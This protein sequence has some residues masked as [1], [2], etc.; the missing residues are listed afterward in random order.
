RGETTVAIL[1]A[2]ARRV[3][4]RGS[5][6]VVMQL[7]RPRSSDWEQYGPFL[8]S[9]TLP[10]VECDPPAGTAYVVKGE[11]HPNGLA[12]SHYARCITDY[13]RT[14][15]AR[16]ESTPHLRASIGRNLNKF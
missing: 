11:G 12:H 1:A 7:D 9:S 4:E 3:A 8:Q 16:P 2:M 14:L 13:L 6:L 10:Y 15:T 5:Q